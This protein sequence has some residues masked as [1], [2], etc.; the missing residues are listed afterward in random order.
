MI[1]IRK[2]SAPSTLAPVPALIALAFCT[3][4]SAQSIAPSAT[5][6]RPLA[7]P[8]AG[9]VAYDVSFDNAVRHEARITVTFSGVPAGKALQAIM[10]R[11][12]PGRYAIHDFAKN[13]YDVTAT[14]GAGRHIALTHSTPYEWD[15]TGH[16][17]TVKITYT[18]FADYA[19]GTYAG[20]DSTHAHF[21]MPAGFMWA[22]GFDMRPITIEFHPRQGWKV[23]TQLQT[24]RNPFVFTAPHLQYF[25]DSPTELSNYAL[26]EWTA[27]PNDSYTLRLAVHTIAPDSLIDRYAAMAKRVVAE[28][29]AVWGTYPPYDD[30]TY[31]FLAD[32]LPWVF[33]DGMEHRNSTI[34]SSGAPLSAGNMLGLLGTL[35]HEHFHSW[36][37]ERLRDKAI[38]PFDFENADMS[39]NL[40]FGEGFTQYYTPLIPKRAGFT[41]FAAYARGLGGTINAVVNGAGRAHNS[42]V[43]MSQYAPFADAAVSNDLTNQQNTFISYYTYGAAIGLG[44]DLTLRTRFDQTLDG[45][46]RMLWSK[47]GSRQANY[48]PLRP[49]TTTDLRTTLG[50][51]TGDAAFAN[52][53]FA[54]YIEGKEAID[55]APLLARAGLLLRSAAAGKAALGPI[56]AQYDSTGALVRA[57]TVEGM[58][59]YKA[60]I[61]NGDRIL[62]IDGKALT[63]FQVLQSIISAHKPGD[64]VAVRYSQRGQTKSGM[65]TFQD[66]PRL[67]VVLFEDAGMTVTAS[68]TAL[69]NAWTGTQIK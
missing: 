36:N 41:E 4:A 52:D 60:G 56:A 61:E 65:I 2:F 44:L 13:V 31:T 6:H 34:I 54:R 42:A 59:F 50:E 48:T 5:A 22:R 49:Y 3:L 7:R 21:N 27:G 18:L 58:S 32:Y 40:W 26:R 14:N 33:G 35:V 20:I 16:D 24:T 64:A 19:D 63:S 15:A 11:T 45:Y 37:M 46:M 17:G 68:M 67:E 38:E 1:S 47:F 25:M 66:D 39:P 23:A 69:R 57:P 9:A 29:A 28:E 43:Q 53:F 51:Y 62:E 10:S 8:S 55:Y 12:S 30:N